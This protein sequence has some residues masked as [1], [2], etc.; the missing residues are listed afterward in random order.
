[1]GKIEVTGLRNFSK[2]LT[3]LAKS[4]M[5]ISKMA[6]YDGAAALADRVKANI[7]ALPVSDEYDRPLTDGQKYNVITSGLKQELAA[8][9]GISEMRENDGSVNVIMGFNSPGYSSV[10]TKKYPKGLPLQMIARSIESG[11][12]V[13]E[14]H[15][16][17]RPAVNAAKAEAMAAMEK[18]ALAQIDKI[19]K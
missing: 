1:M 16:F 7:N 12:S 3:D 13:R 5:A 15:P 8:S 17:V 9:F 14:K 6:L 18:T 4:G 11:S 10:K 2:E 19:T